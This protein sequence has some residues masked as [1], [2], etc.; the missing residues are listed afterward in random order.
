MNNNKITISVPT[1]CS[2]SWEN[3][4]PGGNGRFCNSC[5]QIVVDFTTMTNDEILA[6][7]MTYKS[8]KIC[9]HFN[10]GQ[11]ATGKNK[12]HKYLLK[13]YCSAYEIKHNFLKKATILLLGSV[14]TITGCDL[15]AT[16]KIAAEDNRTTGDSIALPIDS[17]KNNEPK[18]D[19]LNN[20]TFKSK[21][22]R[23]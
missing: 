22:T 5:K 13:A 17:I 3:M 16:G 11:V 12:F 6:Y 9:G 2:E 7:F 15:G 1:P 8:D 20:S 19:S 23:K 18:K 10:R 14:L 4:T 21:R